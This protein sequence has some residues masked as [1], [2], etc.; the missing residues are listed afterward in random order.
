MTVAQ[1]CN[2]LS[3]FPFPCTVVEFASGGLG[4]IPKQA[5]AKIPG[6]GITWNCTTWLDIAFLLPDLWAQVA[7]LAP[8]T[9]P[10]RSRRASSPCTDSSATKFA[11]AGLT[12]TASDVVRLPR[13]AKHPPN[14]GQ[15]ARAHTGRS[16]SYAEKSLSS[17]FGRFARARRAQ[18]LSLSLTPGPAPPSPDRTLPRS[19]LAITEFSSPR[20]KPSA[21][22]KP[23]RARPDPAE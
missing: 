9:G 1:Q 10:P 7:R 3:P 6:E 13:V 4:L 21:A 15:G 12:P 18:C 14:G 20:V 17:T 23:A 2:S 16:G 11:A 22:S 8:L 19:R 5:D